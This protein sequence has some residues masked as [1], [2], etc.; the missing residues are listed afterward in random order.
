M[1]LVEFIKDLKILL[2]GKTVIVTISIAPHDMDVQ[3]LVAAADYVNLMAYDLEGWDGISGYNAPLYHNSKM[4]VDMS[5]D[6]LFR[7]HFANLNIDK[8]KLILGFPL[9]GRKFMTTTPYAPG[10]QAT[11]V[12][13]KDLPKNCTR[14]WDSE[15][16][17]PYL[18]C[19]G[20]YISYDDEQSYAAKKLFANTNGL[21]GMFFWALGQDAGVITAKVKNIQ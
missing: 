12:E 10:Y 14:I 6:Y 13:Y 17:V 9:Y 7:T 8:K 1:L 15:S 18:S 2:P 20:F 3:A 5:I 19:N 11:E 16:Q 21:G 4:R